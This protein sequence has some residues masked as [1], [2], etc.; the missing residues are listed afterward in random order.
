M[1]GYW[2]MTGP[3]APV[4]I[5]DVDAPAVSGERFAALK[6]GFAAAKALIALAAVA[7][8][9][10]DGGQRATL[11]AYHSQLV[12]PFCLTAVRAYFDDLR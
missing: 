12:P 10:S 7:G 4:T 2:A 1:Q 3:T 9:A 11:E 6:D 5:L 8:G